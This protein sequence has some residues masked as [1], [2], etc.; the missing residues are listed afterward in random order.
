MIN[1]I[2][3]IGNV[4]ADPDIRY[5]RNGKTMASISVATT[6]NW[7]NADGQ[8]ESKTEWHRIKAFGYPA[9]Y[10]A[11]YV[12]KGM[13]VYVEG[14]MTYGRYEDKEGITR[15]TAEVKPRKIKILG[16]KSENTGGYQPPP[17][18]TGDDVPF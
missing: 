1:E 3:L 16:R 12:K 10:I 17:P 11:E 2:R 8:W 15:Y 13:Q 18:S 9:E 7:K 6:E 5:T 4:G 14:S